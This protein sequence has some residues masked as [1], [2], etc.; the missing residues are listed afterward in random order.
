MMSSIHALFLFV[1][2]TSVL[3]GEDFPSINTDAWRQMF[4][5][6]PAD[7]ALADA[8]LPLPENPLTYSVT[9]KGEIAGFD[10]GRIFLDITSSPNAYSV[11]YRM[12]QRGVARWFSDA[13]AS[14]HARGVY[15]GNNRISAHYYF[16][17]DYER[18]DDQQFVQLYR[19][20]GERR[21]HLWTNPTYTFHE[22][23]TEDLALDAVDPMGALMSLGFPEVPVRTIALQP[24]PTRI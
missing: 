19:P 17:H 3:S 14:T 21:L 23:V 2:G 12:E 16:N 22:S 13:E 20:E 18:D 4:A 24:N 9:F 1:A 15:D 6:D 7:S 11:D 5:V 8:P 10:V